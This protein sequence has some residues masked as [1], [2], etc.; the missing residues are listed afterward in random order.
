VNF[1]AY[2]LQRLYRQL[3]SLYWLRR[4]REIHSVILFIFPKIRC[5]SPWRKHD[6]KQIVT[7]MIFGKNRNVWPSHWHDFTYYNIYQRTI[8]L[9]SAA[10]HVFRYVEIYC[11]TLPLF[12]YLWN[13]PFASGFLRDISWRMKIESSGK[14]A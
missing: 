1:Y 14:W 9:I 8:D 4:L 13:S 10:V 3:S 2:C 5:N 6:E 11:P 7:K 12:S